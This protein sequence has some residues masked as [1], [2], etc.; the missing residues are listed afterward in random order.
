MGLIIFQLL[1]LISSKLATLQGHSVADI[2]ILREID[3]GLLILGTF[4][5]YLKLTKTEDEDF[6]ICQKW[7]FFRGFY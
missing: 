1:L 6:E 5:Y 3:F 2:Q 4:L 7:L